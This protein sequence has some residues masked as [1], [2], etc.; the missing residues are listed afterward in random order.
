MND[1][2]YSNNLLCLGLSFFKW[3]KDHIHFVE[4]WI[5]N[6]ISSTH[7]R[8]VYTCMH[9]HAF[10]YLYICVCG[11]EDGG[12]ERGVLLTSKI[13]TRIVLCSF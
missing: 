11:E 7:V 3:M 10:M 2:S 13:L 5:H 9:A 8:Y 12:W 6:D 1:G 4:E